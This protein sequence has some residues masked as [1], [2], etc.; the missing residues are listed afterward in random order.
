M[1][2]EAASAPPPRRPRTWLLVLLGV[3]VIAAVAMTLGRSAEPQPPASNPSRPPQQA[4]GERLDPEALDVRIEKLK[5]PLPIPDDSNRNPFR[6]KPKPT[7]PAPRPNPE[8]ALPT[9]PTGPPP[10]PPPPPI[11]P[12]TLKFIGVTEAPGIGKIAALTDCRIT[13]QG[14]EGE[15]VYG[16]YRIVKIG[17]ES[18][19][20]EYS[21]GKGRTTLRMSGQGCAGSDK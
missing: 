7:P 21:D 16:R 8:A 9:T 5:D 19:V 14:R 11:P 3:I 20:I 12:I 2:T 15:M 6:F 1:D 4:G 10:P 17:I 18:L 13:E